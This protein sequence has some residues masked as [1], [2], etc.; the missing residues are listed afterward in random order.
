VTADKIVLTPELVFDVGRLVASFEK[1]MA[2]FETDV[3]P[4]G[5][6]VIARGLD[7]L[8][9]LDAV[10]SR[11]CW[12]MDIGD[13][14]PQWQRASEPFVS[15]YVELD[16]N[17]IHADIWPPNVIC[18]GATVVGLVDFDDCLYGATFIDVAITLLEFSMFQDFVVDEELAVA[19]LAG[20]FQHGGMLS[21][22]EEDLIVNAIEMMYVIWLAYYVSQSPYFEEAEKYLHRLNLLSDDAFRRRLRVDVERC[23]HKARSRS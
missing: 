11:R 2:L 20:Y 8:A 14:I 18:E 21:A 5:G 16:S 19:L 7:G 12:E 3:I 4:D 9:S 23:I 6:T 10:L 22:L 17:V 15:N 13:V 1:A